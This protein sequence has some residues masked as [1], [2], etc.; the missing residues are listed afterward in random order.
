MAICGCSKLSGN[1]AGQI[2]SHP[3][4]EEIAKSYGDYQAITTQP[5]LVN[6]ELAMLCVGASTA[7]VDAARIKFGPHANTAISIYMNDAAA[8]AFRERR[9]YPVGAVVV[10]RKRLMSYGGSNSVSPG[11]T[12]NGVGGMVKRSPGYDS[13]HGDWEYFYY[14][15]P[16][17][18]ESGQIASCV[19]CHI[20][21][22]TSDYVFGSWLDGRPRN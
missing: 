12:E 11:E 22:K 7:Q 18:I 19:Q 17:H 9:S 21:A 2:T 1:Q 13:A 5:V 20:G 16:D 6:P 3:T 15:R 14:D 4:V 10:K 8:N